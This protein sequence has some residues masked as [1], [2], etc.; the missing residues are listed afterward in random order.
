MSVSLAPP[1]SPGRHPDSSPPSTIRAEEL[2]RRYRETNDP[3]CRARAIESHLPL[4]HKLARRYHPGPEPLDDLVQ[5]ACVGLVKAIDRFDPDAG[6]RFASFA[7][8]TITGE[9]RRHFRDTTWSV[10]V[11]RGVQEDAL[12]LRRA[13]TELSER[14]GRAPTVG[15]LT[16]ATGLDA[17]QITE[18]L[19][20]TTAKAT[21]SLDRPVLGHDD[22][23]GGSVT[24]GDTI[25]AD[26][27]GFVLAEHR[28]ALAPRLRDLSPRDR[29]LLR[30]RFVEDM[31][32]LEIAQRIGCS[33]MQVSRLL[34]RALEQL[35]R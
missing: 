3:R 16:A 10:H 7:I 29:E 31:T 4:A 17:E 27:H 6:Y 35:A 28:S 32:Q 5:V 13:T 12:R 26:D 15:E 1:A 19:H 22:G 25:G 9:L 23:S 8:P 2:I 20:A 34:R 18:A 11:P 21:A 30:L 33:Q 14:S 24:V